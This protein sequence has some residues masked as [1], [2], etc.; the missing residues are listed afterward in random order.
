MPLAQKP[1]I[2]P[3]SIAF[4]ALTPNDTP[5]GLAGIGGGAICTLSRFGSMPHSFSSSIRPMSISGAAPILLAFDG[6]DVAALHLEVR[7]HDQEPV[8]VLR[9]RAEE[10]H[11]LPFRKRRRRRMRRAADEVGLAVAQRLVAL[12]DRIDQLELGI[13]ALLLEE[14]H[15]H[16]RDGGEVRVGD[17]IGNDDFHV[18][19]LS[20]SPTSSLGAPKARDPSDRARSDRAQP[21]RDR[22]DA[23]HDAVHARQATPH[24]AA[25]RCL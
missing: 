23:R 9:Q 13:E 7:A 22:L 5:A 3:S 16:R 12:A 14:A 10:L 11:A 17:E 4:A 18:L 24:P 21:D 6:A 19:L 2:L 8:G 1:S 25:T 15:L 20:V